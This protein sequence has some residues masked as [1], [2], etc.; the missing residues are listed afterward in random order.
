[1]PDLVVAP[2]T[3]TTVEQELRRVLL[4]AEVPFNDLAFRFAVRYKRAHPDLDPNFE[5]TPEMRD[6]FVAFLEERTG[7]DLDEDVLDAAG[8]L[9]DFQLARQMAA[10][11]FGETAGLQRAVRRSR[12]VREA[13]QLLSG[14]AT[15]EELMA[16]AEAKREATGPES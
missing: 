8:D 5:V 11:A 13:V 3:L 16:R 1:M 15:P 10:A 14:T 9:V 2:D 6:E 4:D 7:A 12:Q